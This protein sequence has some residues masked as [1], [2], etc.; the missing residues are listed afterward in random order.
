MCVNAGNTKFS[1]HQ[2]N[3][4]TPH[5]VVGCNIYGWIVSTEEWL[6][7]IWESLSFWFCVFKQWVMVSKTH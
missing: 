4:I 2:H 1:C 7:S 3:K 6:F 5:I